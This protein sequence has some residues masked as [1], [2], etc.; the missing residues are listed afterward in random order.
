[1]TRGK[2]SEEREK[3]EGWMEERGRRASLISMTRSIC[4]ILFFISPSPCAICPGN[5]FT[6]IF[7]E[8]CKAK[9]KGKG[10]GKERERQRFC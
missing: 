2:V 8:G 4:L 5:Q 10:K 9:G 7:F 1:M 3:R 6:F